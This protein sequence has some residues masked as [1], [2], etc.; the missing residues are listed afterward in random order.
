[1]R[2]RGLREAGARAA[3]GRGGVGAS[4]RR[5][6]DPDQE[7]GGAGRRLGSEHSPGPGVRDTALGP[8]DLQVC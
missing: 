7:L 5:Q 1:M 2:P 8:Q 6:G 4:G 3:A